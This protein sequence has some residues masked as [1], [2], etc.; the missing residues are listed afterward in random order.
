MIS[1]LHILVGHIHID[2][3][4]YRNSNVKIMPIV[5]ECQL[6]KVLASLT[7]TN[8]NFHTGSSIE[9]ITKEKIDPFKGN[10]NVDTIREV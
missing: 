3:I 4:R 8:L 1:A 6:G 5:P 2:N 10:S 9:R 7:Q